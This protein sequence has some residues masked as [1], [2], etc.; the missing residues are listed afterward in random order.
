[1]SKYPYVKPQSP[2]TS[3]AIAALVEDEPGALT[4]VGKVTLQRALFMSPGL[5]LAGVAPR[6]VIKTALLTS[7]S[8]SGMLYLY[9][10]TKKKV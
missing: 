4:A 6:K 1:M 2:P 7:A 10:S 5:L 3:Y 8:I 9:Y